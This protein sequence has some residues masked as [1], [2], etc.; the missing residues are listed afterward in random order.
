MKVKIYWDQSPW[1][2]ELEEL[3]V[4]IRDKLLVVAM[5]EVA[6]GLWWQPWGMSIEMA[7]RD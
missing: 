6:H 3:E 5:A 2:Y 4:V 7:G 1:V